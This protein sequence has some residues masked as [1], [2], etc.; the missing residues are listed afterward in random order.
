M[1]HD[2][3][4]FV[5]RNVKWQ[6]VLTDLNGYSFG[7]VDAKSV[8]RRVLENVH[9]RLD[10][11]ADDK[12]VN[13]AFTFLVAMAYSGKGEK[14]T[15]DWA[16]RGI[17]LPS[18]TTEF[19][20]A[21]HVSRSVERNIQSREY[22]EIAKASAIDTITTWYRKY[23][24]EG[25][26]IFGAKKT[27]DEIWQQASDGSGFCELSRIFFSK[28]TER[29]LSYFIEREA[30]AHFSDWDQIT[31]FRSDLAV[32][33]DTLSK[34]AFETAKITQSFAAG[35]YNKNTKEGLPTSVQVRRFLATAF[36]KLKEEFAM[37][38]ASN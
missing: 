29:Y 37:E 24:E 23:R 33:I 1:G 4:G 19:L 20:V 3:L 6:R 38:K 26:D 21:K 32:S 22:G 27:P 13:A 35:W 7:V 9:D 8:G 25:E 5:P 17:E 30:G 34:Y 18:E 31:R 36:G 2:R 10:N 15:K 11:I 16:I 28:F 12:G 14:R